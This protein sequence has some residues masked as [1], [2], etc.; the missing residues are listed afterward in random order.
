[1]QR[2]LGQVNFIRRFISNSAGKVQAFNPLLKLKADE[3]FIWESVHR[4]A[5]KPIKRY[6]ASPPILM[7]PIKGRPLILYISA[8]DTS[9]GSLLA[10]NNDN[11]QQRAIYYLSGSLSTVEQCYSAIE[12][13]CLSLYFASQKYRAYLLPTTVMVVCKTDLVKYMLSRPILHGRLG[14]WALF[15][16]SYAPRPLK[17]RH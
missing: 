17:A 16:I 9:I 14:K 12:K 15:S 10:Q 13:L 11:E 6:L 4:E 7:P 2:F 1:M 5:F 3:E 8:S